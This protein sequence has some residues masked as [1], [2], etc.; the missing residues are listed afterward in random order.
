MNLTREGQS[1]NFKRGIHDL[2]GALAFTMA[3][4]NAAVFAE[5]KHARNG[6]Q[7]IG[8]LAL[9]LFERSNADCHRESR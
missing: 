3:A 5:K 7:A 4:Y 9:W 1:E 6:L 2:M 8:Y